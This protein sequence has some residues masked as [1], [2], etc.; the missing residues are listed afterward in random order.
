MSLPLA[1]ILYVPT[2]TADIAQAAFPKG[3][4]YLQMRDT[5]GTVYT[6]TDFADLSP[7][8][9][10]PAA[11]PWRLALVTIMQFAENLTDRQ[12]ADAVRG[13]IDW[14][15]ALGLDLTDAGFDFSVLSEFRARLLAGEAVERLLTQMLGL[16][17]E[18]GLLR[19][20]GTQRT[21]STP[22][23]AAVRDLNRLALV[24]VSALWP[25]VFGLSA[26]QRATRPATASGNHG[27]R[28]CAPPHADVWG[29]SSGGLTGL[30]GS[31][32]IAAGMDS[33]ILS[34]RWGD[35]LA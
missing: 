21:D 6:N 26:P 31:G 13:R 9:G 10:Q 30:S 32:D 29:R 1:S 35:P 14:K 24:M 25:A 20:R 28:R 19:A 7:P 23:V 8:V 15:Y 22:V 2:Q 27:T 11:A 5:L 3:N 17:V 12:A 18:R 16:L 33:T 34:G 4:R